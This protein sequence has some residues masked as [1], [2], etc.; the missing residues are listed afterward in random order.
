MRK[1]RPESWLISL[2]CAVAAASALADETASTAPAARPPAATP[3]AAT[4][5]AASPP[6]VTPPAATPPV[7]SPPA[8]TGTE[9][10]HEEKLLLAKGYRPTTRN[11]EKVYCKREQVLGSRL[12][13][14]QRCGTLAQLKSVT[15]SS[16]N[17]AEGIQQHQVNPMGK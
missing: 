2:V 1:P 7:A 11:G 13:Y 10:G 12:D 8:A 9:S 15:E 4:P 17:F 3:P 16:R 6:A 5:P 14:V